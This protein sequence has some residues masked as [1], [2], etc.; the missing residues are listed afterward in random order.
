[1]HWSKYPSLVF[2][3]WL[4]TQGQLPYLLFTNH[5]EYGHHKF[6]VNKDDTIGLMN[7]DHEYVLGTCEDHKSVRWVKRGD[8][9]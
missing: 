8:P 9:N 4:K 2:D 7:T 1:M 5:L 6:F 3:G